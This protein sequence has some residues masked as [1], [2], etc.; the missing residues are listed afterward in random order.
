MKESAFYSTDQLLQHRDGR[1]LNADSSGFISSICKVFAVSA[2]PLTVDKFSSC[3]MML[4]DLN[5]IIFLTLGQITLVLQY[6]NLTL[7][8]TDV[9]V[10]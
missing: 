3:G 6:I 2:S 7:R 1:G 5:Y 10:K 9:V 8:T 4:K